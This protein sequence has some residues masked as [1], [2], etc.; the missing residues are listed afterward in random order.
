[1]TNFSAPGSGG[2]HNNSRG[3][4]LFGGLA[5]IV[6]VIAGI[7]LI[8]TYLFRPSPPG[9]T[10]SPLEVAGNSAHVCTP[11][12]KPTASG[13]NWVAM[14]DSTS[15]AYFT[16]GDGTGNMQIPLTGSWSQIQFNALGADKSLLTL[17]AGGARRPAGLL[18]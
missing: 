10:D 16:K 17:T 12:S 18:L 2:T 1:M 5:A 4:R 9:G 7:I 3:L 8:Y 6:A 15:L 14:V 13:S 11:F